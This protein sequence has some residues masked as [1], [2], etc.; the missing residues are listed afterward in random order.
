MWHSWTSCG[1]PCTVR[2]CSYPHGTDRALLPLTRWQST[3][4]KLLWPSVQHPSI[5]QLNMPMGV[6][7][8]S[9][10]EWDVQTGKYMNMMS[11]RRTL[12]PF[13]NYRILQED[14]GYFVNI[15]KLLS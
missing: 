12:M 10:F 13:L 15:L 14:I 9:Y 11:T 6:A 4:W 3:K 2:D 7:D 8:L 1:N 5:W